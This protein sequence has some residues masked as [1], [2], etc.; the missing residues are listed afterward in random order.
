MADDFN[1]WT[2]KNGYY[3]QAATPNIDALADK[4][5][6]FTDA[7]SASPVCHPSRNA[8][9]SGIHP[10]TSG[11]T[12]NGQPFIRDV[13]GFGNI[14][15][16]HQYFSQNGYHTY[17]SGKLWHPS[18]M[19]PNN[20]VVDPTN[21]DEIN[22]SGTGA[23][24][25][26]YKS[27]TLAANKAWSWSG[28]ENPITSG[29]TKDFALASQV[30]DYISNY[31][32]QKPF[33]IACG[34][35]RPHMPWRSPK[36]FWDK[37]DSS[38]LRPPPGYDPATDGNG[39][40][41]KGSAAHRDILGNEKWEDA[42]HAYL[43]ACALADHNVG[44][45]LDSLETS[46]FDDNTIIIFVGD[47][48]WSLGEKGHWGKFSV[49]DE[50]N[51]TTMIIYDPASV[52]NGQS[53]AKAVSLQD[54]YP[55]LV[56]LCGLPT[57]TQV[58]GKSL[59]PI[60]DKPQSAS[61]TSPILMKYGDTEYMKT[62]EY[63]FVE[64]GSD[65][66]LYHN[67]SDPY[68]RTNLYSQNQHA[69]TVSWFRSEMAIHKANGQ[70]IKSELTAKLEAYNYPDTII[71][72]TNVLDKDERFVAETRR[73]SNYSVRV[74]Q[75]DQSQEAFVMYT[76]NPHVGGNL[77]LSPNTHWTNF[78]FQGQV[79][80]TVTNLS[81]NIS[82]CEI[83]PSKKGHSANINGNQATFS[84]STA[85]GQ[86][87]LQ[88]SLRINKNDKDP[89]LIFADPP[90]SDIPDRTD[91]ANVELIDTT[92]NIEVVRTKLRS[93]KPYVV[94]E[95][96][97]HS[98]GTD[99]TNAYPGYRLPYVSN[100]KIYLPGGAYVIGTFDGNSVS[101]SKIYGRGVL[102]ACG[103]N[104]LAQSESIPYSM[105]HQTGNATNQLIEGIVT[106]DPPHFHLT[107]RGQ[108][109]ID[110]VKMIGYWH[111]TDGTVTGDNSIVKNT[112]MKT[113]D[114]YIKVY[115][116][117]CY[118]VNNTM[119]HQVNGAPFQFCWSS[120][121]GDNNLMED[122]YIINSSYSPGE[123]N[124]LNTAVI[125]ARNGSEAIT[126]NNTWDGIY[127]DNGCHKLI[128]LNA[129]DESAS[130]FRNFLIKNVELNTGNADSPQDGGSYL[131]AGDSSNFINIHFENLKINGD[132]ISGTNGDSDLDV[133]RAIWFNSGGR[134]SSYSISH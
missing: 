71:P 66:E 62:Q 14:I 59:K 39:S 58:E 114:D 35:F 31:D 129:Q 91:T 65:S 41:G 54:L 103:K 102:S 32:K 9:W 16:L 5:V 127:I 101:N 38:N 61:W 1:Y 36:E 13:P 113:N 109:T 86:I 6:F 89:L 51:H 125:C 83:F 25:G 74:A 27:Y 24:G 26:E 82:S 73:S 123:N 63:R 90:E 52:G 92:D 72:A 56:E 118:H 2:S 33:F 11:I 111:Q 126:E 17:G 22:S 44:V 115:S 110:N 88:L 75:K 8:L 107:Y 80:V 30:A 128:G 116:Q 55:T 50:A 77:G 28:N 96:G 133:D 130:I 100:K 76:P 87:P 60:L 97:I 12:R 85:N 64:N 108:V 122:T 40:D 48:G 49:N 104:R 45:I 105:V 7:H 67:A 117:N 4:G 42:I 121:N 18:R 19:D 10:S 120:Q 46:A 47:H 131:M 78:S 79:D 70:R 106:T 84:L 132:P 57:N 68:N 43:A 95:E 94:F 3:P 34:L 15:S 23:N 99:Q 69:E 53:C 20:P 134:F 98:Y 37:I 93:A 112:F 21:W 29:N 124:K 119:F 81:G